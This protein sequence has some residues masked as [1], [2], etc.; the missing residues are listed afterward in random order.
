M[1][2]S[3]VTYS[4]RC[5][6]YA[7]LQ[8]N[9]S[10]NAIA[11][12]LNLHRSTIYRELKR[13]SS[14]RGY[15]PDKAQKNYSSKF[16]SCRRKEVISKELKLQIQE[17]LI[18]GWSPEQVA[19]RMKLEGVIFPCTQTLYNF[20]K[21]H[22]LLRVYLR[23]YNKRG[24]GRY[25]QRKLSQKNIKKLKDRPKIAQRRGRTGDWERDLFYGANKKQ[26]LICTDRKTRYSMLSRLE[27]ATG[28]NVQKATIKLLKRSKKRTYTMT[29]DNGTEFKANL[30][31]GIP[32]YFC[33]PLRP[34]QRGTVENTIGLIRQYI[35]RKTDLEKMS[36]REI[37]NIEDILNKRPRKIL[38]FK[39]P[40]ELFNNQ[41]VAL[42]VGM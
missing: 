30:P 31:I 10:I 22:Q 32:I 20:I 12:E 24:A 40:Y 27:R 37:R 41:S 9:F 38:G 26:I 39:T 15:N 1:Q 11:T 34:D 35:T 17:Y 25:K 42:A 7:F 14:S 4:Q 18:K 19:G 21:K 5:Q 33:K 3:R 23:R 13:N 36:D 2:Y 6:I 29:N 8:A 16:K 28:E